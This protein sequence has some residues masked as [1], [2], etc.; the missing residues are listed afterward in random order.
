MFYRCFPVIGAVGGGGAFLFGRW[1]LKVLA[2]LGLQGRLNRVARVSC[3][4]AGLF[5][6]STIII[7]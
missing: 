1:L 6:D 2:D 7:R 4:T 5:F 3:V